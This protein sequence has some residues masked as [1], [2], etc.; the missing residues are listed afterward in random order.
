[1]CGIIGYSGGAQAAPILLDGLE[2]MEYRGYD[3]AGVAVRSETHGLQV[4]KSKG[5]LK[6]L[7]DL[8]HGG[9]DLEGTLGV[10]HTRW[11]THGEPNDV[12]AHPHVSES[13]NIALVHNGII[14][15]YMEI[16]EHLQ[17]LGVKFTSDTDSEVVAQLLEFH[18]NECHN[19][20][21]AVGRVLRRIEGSYAFGIICSDYPDAL[22]AARKDSPL[23]LGYGKDCN[24]IA[25]DVTA[26][27]KYTRD[28][29]YMDD[30]EIAVVTPRG[31][32]VF[33]GELVPV[34]KTR[35][36][37]DWDVS[38]A[39]KGGYPHFMLKEIMEQ[40]DAVRRT[41]SPRIREGR[42]V[43][44][45]V[46][47]TREYAENVSRIFII[48]CGSSYHVGMVSKYIW[49]KLL[50]RPVEV[51]LASE[52]RYCDPLVDERSL[53][54]VISQSG[55]TLDTMAAMR[56]AKRRGGRTLAIVNVVG[57]S[58]ARDADDVLYTWAGPE[59]AVATTKAYSTQLAL[60]DLV[61]L[62][63]GDLLGTVSK[64]V[65][66]AAVEGIE[67]L[68]Q[69]MSALLKD[70]EDVKYL[71]SRYFNHDSIF[72]IGRN[73]D[74]AMGMEGSLKLKEI[75]YIHS[76]AYASGELKHG[77]ISL[78]EPGT[79]VVA[80]G[81]YTPLFDKAMSN[82]VEVK[83]RGAEV[84]ALTT[85]CHREK[86]EKTA[87]AVLSV[88]ETEEMLQPSLGVLPLQLF[89]YYVALQRGCDIDKPRNLAKSVTVE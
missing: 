68:P 79:L 37:V 67:R 33:D 59:I 22:I 47:L 9:A 18:Y 23:I 7:S 69:Q 27:I 72:F 25:S 71:A 87:D 4:I 15:N 2:R 89:S 60:M 56:E 16:K 38:A 6:V 41:V 43:L 8:L 82:V 50:R 34:E 46:K 11:A 88:P 14:E 10:G 29:A 86:M 3:S 76:E 12:N 83:A 66:A 65:Y 13:G 54:V 17:K 1:M 73:L 70:T 48:A 44:D 45:D 74:Y 85:V 42:V 84:L 75:S 24:F 78:I 53:V 36:I 51:V 64:E 61:G 26:V 58:I 31:I 28:V 35:R 81:S 32:D 49:E 55:E 62:Y 63:L 19:M 30:G 52:F 20:L 5:R 77:T 40:P 21:E 39:E 80:L 57:S